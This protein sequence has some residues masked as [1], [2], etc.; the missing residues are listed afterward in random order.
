MLQSPLD[1]SALPLEI[2]LVAYLL[3]GPLASVLLKSSQM[4]LLS[5]QSLNH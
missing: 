2:D 4:I 3:E 5:I 1:T